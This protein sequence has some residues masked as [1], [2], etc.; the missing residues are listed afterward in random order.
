MVP[1]FGNKLYTQICEHN[2]DSC[3]STS[4]FP[5]DALLKTIEIAQSLYEKTTD[6]IDASVSI[7]NLASTMDNKIN[8]RLLV[9]A[10]QLLLSLPMDSTNTDISETALITRYIVPLLQ[11]LFDEFRSVHYGLDPENNTIGFLEPFAFQRCVL[12]LYETNAPG[13]NITNRL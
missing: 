6:R 13:T 7:L 10:S 5:G 12:T 9:S 11:H 3:N 2:L 4:K 1:F 8:K